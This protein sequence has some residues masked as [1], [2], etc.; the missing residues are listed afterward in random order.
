LKHNEDMPPKVSLSQRFS[1]WFDL[2]RRAFRYRI[3]GIGILLD[4]VIYDIIMAEIIRPII[5]ADAWNKMVDTYIFA[6]FGVFAI[7]LVLVLLI[8]GANWRTVLWF[9]TPFW[10]NWHDTLFWL[11]Q[12]KLPPERLGFLAWSPTR[13]QL[14]I[15]NIVG[16]FVII[17]IEVAI[18][19]TWER[20]KKETLEEL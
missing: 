19:R 11:I 8:A 10:F 13:T 3:A 12:G 1:N 9:Y 6:F 4:F 17:G 14:I 16:L 5:G 2:S 20:R 7:I 18:T 15:W